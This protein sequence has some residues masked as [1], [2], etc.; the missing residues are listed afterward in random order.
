MFL[1][2]IR[3]RLGVTVNSYNY[4]VLHRRDFQPTVFNNLESHIREVLV[5]VLEGLR[6]QV[7]LV[8]ACIGTE[9]LSRANELEIIFRVQRIAGAYH[10]VACHGVFLAVIRNR[11]GITLNPYNYFVLHRRDFQLAVLS[12]HI[13]LCRHIVVI[14]ILHHCSAGYLCGVF[15]SID[16]LGFCI[17][18]GKRVLHILVPDLDRELAVGI[19]VDRNAGNRLFAAIV[20]ECSTVGLNSD[21]V[22]FISFKASHSQSAFGLGDLVV[23][24]L[25]VILQLV[26]ECVCTVANHSLAA[27][28]FVG[29]AFAFYPTSFCF[30]SDFT[31]R[32]SGAIVLL[33]QIGRLQD[34]RPFG[35]IQG[36]CCGCRFVVGLGCLYFYGLGAHIFDSRSGRCPIASSNNLVLD[37]CAF[38]YID[39]CSVSLAV[40]Y[41]VVTLNCHCHGCR[42]DRQRAVRS[43]RN[44]VLLGYINGANRFFLEGG[45]I[46]AS[47]DAGGAN[48]DITEVCRVVLDSSVYSFN[49]ADGLFS[50]IVGCHSAI[51]CEFYILVIVENDFIGSGSNGDRFFLCT[52][53]R[54]VARDSCNNNFLGYFFTIGFVGNDLIIMNLLSRTIPIVMHRVA[55][56]RALCPCAGE[57][58]ILGRHGKLAVSYSQTLGFFDCPAGEGIA[59]QRGSSCH[60]HLIITGC[61]LATRGRRCICRDFAIIPILNLKLALLPLGH[62]NHIAI[63]HFDCAVQHIDGVG[64]LQF[65]AGEGIAISGRLRLLYGVGIALVQRVV[66]DRIRRTRPIASIR[67]ICHRMG[68]SIL[69]IVISVSCHRLARL[70]EV[71]M[72]HFGTRFFLP[73]NKFVLYSAHRLECRERCC[74]YTIQIRRM[75]CAFAVDNI[76]FSA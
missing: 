27:G 19:A 36:V 34:D 18:A 48:G 53:D 8:G 55:Q 13:E 5:V 9:S 57:S 74:R 67:L 21:L 65:P 25:R 73:T 68:S 16:A 3:N 17:Q 64:S 71:N 50:A 32:Q 47:V 40:I 28:K 12:F 30:K 10:F 29:C 72:S 11:L 26:V 76:T 46:C 37:R 45:R 44:N 56:V 58:H 42:I 33:A 41:T 20:L 24:S 66:H 52:I 38:R 1:A 7:H 31:V 39:L 43:V 75:G 35:Y 63:R 6:L 14:S 59:V 70:S 51:G 60:S 62:Q 4:F 49:S 54:S 15:I 22:P 69:G 61:L 23:V 2:V